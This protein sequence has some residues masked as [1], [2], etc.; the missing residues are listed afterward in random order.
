L[1]VASPLLVG[2]AYA[3]EPP[4]QEQPPPPPAA[5]AP[6]PAPP[7]ATDVQAASPTA[8]EPKTTGTKEVPSEIVSTDPD[9]KTVR[10]KVMVK[11]DADA[12]P[13]M[14]E[15]TLPVDAEAVPALATFHAGDKVKLLCR[16]NGDKVIAVKSIKKDEARKSE[17]PAN[18]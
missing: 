10:V 12:E 2:L 6:Q 9:A 3:Q 8:A 7:A 16:M 1:L 13:A 17:T 18:R 15:G 14:Q 4:R 11:K 5:A